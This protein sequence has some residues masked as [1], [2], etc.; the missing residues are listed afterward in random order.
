MTKISAV[1]ITLNEQV[2]IGRCLESLRGIADEIVVVD[3]FSTDRTKEICLQY[4]TRFLEHPFASYNEQKNFAVRQAIHPLVLSLDA[5]EMLSPELRQS[6]LE[7]KQNP[8][9]DGYSIN[10]LTNYCGKWIRHA[11]YPDA[12]LRLWNVTKG[13]WD[14]SVI[15][16]KVTMTAGA[17]IGHLKGDLYHYTYYSL[18]GHLSQQHKYAFLS[19]KALFASGK[20]SSL[21]KI[22]VNPF[23]TFVKLY[24]LKQGFRD[25]YEGFLVSRISSLTVFMKYIYLMDLQRK[26]REG[27][28]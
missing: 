11:W 28:V 8:V 26:N 19:A 14:E 3:S 17:T 7:E 22:I 4:G 16:E 27:G 6:I 20:R 9:S 21:V 24:F 12:K 25:G 1:I 23:L 2:N 10:R 5:D 18:E 13:Q 15:H